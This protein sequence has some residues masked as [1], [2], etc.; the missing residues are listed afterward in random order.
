MNNALVSAILTGYAGFTSVAG[1]IG[2]RYKVDHDVSML[3]PELWCRMSVQE[4]DPAYL[5]EHGYLEPVRDFEYEGRR[6]LASR[7]GY[8]ITQGFVKHFLGRMFQTPNAVFSP[9]MLRPELQGLEPFVAGIDALV[10][11][12]TRVATSYFEDG[13]VEAACPPLRALLHVMAFGQYQGWGADDPRFPRAL[14]PRGAARERV[15]PRSARD[16]TTPRRATLAT[17]QDGPHRGR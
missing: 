3:V 7:L 1:Y 14:H 6:V 13:S 9:D 16:Q 4:R 5:I 10:A 12:Q 11:T 8:R 15:V 17:P 2:P